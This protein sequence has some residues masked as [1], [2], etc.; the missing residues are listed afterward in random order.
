ME[1]T[2]KP[3]QTGRGRKLQAGL[4][5]S[6]V[7]GDRGDGGTAD[8]GV[9][10][11]LQPTRPAQCA[12]HAVTRGV[13]CGLESQKHETTCPKLGGAVHMKMKSLNCGRAFNCF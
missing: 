7:P 4:C 2:I 9:D 12:W 11:T 3:V 1:A 13:L 8:P 6:S 5:V 10:R